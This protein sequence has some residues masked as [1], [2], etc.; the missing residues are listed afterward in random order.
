VPA[1]SVSAPPAPAQP[2]PTDPVHTS[3]WVRDRCPSSSRGPGPPQRMRFLTHRVGSSPANGKV[4]LAGGRQ[5]GRL[6]VKIIWIAATLEPCRG[7]LVG[8]IG[9]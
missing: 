1:V 3:A 9:W 6:R 7:C 8:P 5:S 2:T 4:S